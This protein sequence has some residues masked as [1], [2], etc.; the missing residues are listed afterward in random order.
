MTSSRPD[1]LSVPPPEP[2]EGDADPSS[3]TPSSRGAGDR[4]AS[5]WS[6]ADRRGGPVLSLPRIDHRF[7]SGP[8]VAIVA[9]IHGDEVVG[10]GA[11]QAIDRWL[12]AHGG[13]GRVVLFPSVNPQGLARQVRHVP[14][15][16]LDLNRV[17]PGNPR[18]SL[19]SRTAAALWSQL[20]ALDPALVV[21][22]HADALDAIPYAIV[23]RPVRLDPSARRA[24]GTRIEACADATGLTVLREYRDDVYQHFGLDRSLAGCVVNQ[25]GVPAITL[26]VG[27]RRAMRPDD[28]TVSMHAALGA[29][30]A[31]GAVQAPPVV[32]HTR[33]EGPWRRAAPSRPRRGGL[34]VTRCSP[35]DR[36]DA[37]QVIAEVRDLSGERLDVLRAEAPGAV[38]SWIESPWVSAGALVGTLAVADEGPL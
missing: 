9:N 24:L 15:D 18:A 12:T 14:A 28:V 3:Q 1:P 33:I 25:L 6:I 34:L 36:V 5:T 4:V 38:V 30:H 21:D 17:F 27:P 20:Q 22:L 35:G 11:V 31:V 8:T 23:D 10:I 32:H 2:A 13:M 37:G 16:E 29:M 19:A 7:G 26:E